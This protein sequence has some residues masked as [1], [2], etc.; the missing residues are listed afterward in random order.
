MHVEIVFGYD[1]FVIDFQGERTWVS[2]KKPEPKTWDPSPLK[3]GS[4]ELILIFKEDQEALLAEKEMEIEMLKDHIEVLLDEQEIASRSHHS[5]GNIWNEFI[6]SYIKVN[7]L[8]F[9]DEVLYGMCRPF[10]IQL[11]LSKLG[12]LWR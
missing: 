6:S 2:K 4:V 3:I 5:E 1:Q 7:F 11:N 8:F 12:I 9:Y 10:F